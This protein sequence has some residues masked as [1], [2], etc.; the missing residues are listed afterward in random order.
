MSSM[1]RLNSA[2]STTVAPT[3]SG[4]SDRPEVPGPRRSRAPAAQ[5]IH[6][7]STPTTSARATSKDPGKDPTKPMVR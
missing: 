3:T 6:P 2:C 7:A 1:V 5:V 4:M